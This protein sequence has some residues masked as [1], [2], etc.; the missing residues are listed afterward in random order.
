MLDF[1]ARVCAVHSNASE[2]A[3]ASWRELENASVQQTS[4]GSRF[5][6]EYI[7]SA[8]D[9][10]QARTQAMSQFTSDA[11]DAGLFRPDDLLQLFLSDLV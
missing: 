9:R 11:F 6:R 10:A 3:T 2:A 1:R 4:D 5:C 8:N 7:V